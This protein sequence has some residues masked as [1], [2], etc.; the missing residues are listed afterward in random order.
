MPTISPTKPLE[1]T[2]SSSVTNSRVVIF[3]QTTGETEHYNDK[4]E[5]LKIN[6]NKKLLFDANWFASW[7]VGDV[8]ECTVTGKHY[9]NGT[10][11]LTAAAVGPQ[12]K[13]ITVATMALS[14]GGL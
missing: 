5:L 13:S 8:I 14:T 2:F 3:N 11:T 10:I 9:G 12:R 7:S 4:G 6:Q 1:F